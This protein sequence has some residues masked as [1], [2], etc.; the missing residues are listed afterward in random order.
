MIDHS[1]NTES[2]LDRMFREA[3]IINTVEHYRRFVAAVRAYVLLLMLERKPD[4]E[5]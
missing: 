2:V 4:L 3:R 5:T 1:A